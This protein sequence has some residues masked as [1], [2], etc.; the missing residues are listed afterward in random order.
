MSKAPSY[1][2]LS[3]HSVWYFR[4]AV[5]D[6]IRSLIGHRE[7]RRSLQ[8]KY[9]RE[10]LFRSRELLAQVQGVFTEAF[11]GKRPSLD[12]F[13]IDG[14]RPKQGV[15]W[16]EWVKRSLSGVGEA[17]DVPPVAEFGSKLSQVMAEY[18]QRQRLEG[19]SEKTISDK[20][21]VVDLLI[22]ICGDL[23]IKS[24]ARTDA[25]SFRETALKLPPRMNQLPNQ[26]LK[27]VIAEAKSTISITTFNNYVKNLITVFMYAMQEGYCEANPFDGLRI[28]QRVKASE[29]RS[30]F[31]EE[32]LKKLFD[33]KVYTRKDC[34]KPYQYWL[35]LLG[36]YTGARLNELCQLYLDDIV[37]I[38]GIECIHIQASRPDQKLK[39]P[40]S[41]RL[42]PV[43]SKLKE[44]GF[45]GC[46]KQGKALG[47]DMLFDLV[48]HKRHGYVA[49]PSKWFARYRGKLG[50]KN[51][52][53]KKD[54]HSFRHTVADS[55]KQQGVSEAL[56]SGLL[57]HK[58]GGIT[59]RRY[60]KCFKPSVLVDTVERLTFG[61]R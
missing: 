17:Q 46:E 37:T 6:V 38:N 8:T 33:S 45:L 59:F 4:I 12:K 57:G 5:P 61:F 25:Q 40:T 20:E 7:L 16:A 32:D 26:S 54:F 34:A 36:L 60:G 48:R 27:K 35:P 1:L 3:R 52:N 49:T 14:E 50:F 47:Q 2:L 13:G 15:S 43:H 22:R 19:I 30:R 18:A 44:L 55:L 11:Q 42:I 28:K 39:N 53:E 56:V 41:E 24:F 9:K 51:G 10:A 58:T 23:P 29:Q 31:T 21:S